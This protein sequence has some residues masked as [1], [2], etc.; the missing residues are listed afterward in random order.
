M[1]DNAWLFLML[2]IITNNTF[3]ERKETMDNPMTVTE[4]FDKVIREKLSNPNITA[5]EIE[6]LARAYAELTKNNWMKDAFERLDRAS[7]P[8]FGGPSVSGE[9][10]TLAYERSDKEEQ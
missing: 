1:N 6:T 5:A 7:I 3:E 10:A 9:V 2:A 8:G 4:E